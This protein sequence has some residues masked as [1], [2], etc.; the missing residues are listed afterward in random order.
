MTGQARVD[1]LLSYLQRHANDPKRPTAD[2]YQPSL[3][4]ALEGAT[5]EVTPNETP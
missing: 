3:Y 1:W 2:A 5:E 4:D